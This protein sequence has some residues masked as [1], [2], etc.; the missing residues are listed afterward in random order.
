MIIGKGLV[1]IWVVEDIV[2]D[3]V[4]LIDNYREQ[5]NRIILKDGYRALLQKMADRLVKLGGEIPE[6]LQF[7]K[8]PQKTQAKPSAKAKKPAAAVAP[9]ASTK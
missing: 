4:S 1:P 3:E 9:K 2:I 7:L 8:V 5:F 6:G